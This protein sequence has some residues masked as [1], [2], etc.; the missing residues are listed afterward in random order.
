M[1]SKNP[2]ILKEL[3]YTTY[4]YVERVRF[5][6][7]NIIQPDP[8]TNV[9]YTI[10]GKAP[11][12]PIFPSGLTI[13]SG[14]T[15]TNGTEQNGYTLFTDGT[16]YAYWDL[17]PTQGITGIT[18][19]DG[20]SAQTTDNLTTIINIDKGSSQNI[21]KNFKV[22][23]V[24]QFGASSNNDEINFS[25]INLTITSAGT[26]TLVFSAKTGGGVSGITGGTYYPS[27]LTLDLET[28][29]STISINDVTGLY[30]SGGTYTSGTSTLDLFNSTGGTISITGITAGSG[31]SVF[32]GLTQMSEA[33]RT[34]L[35][36]T[37]GYMVYQTDG[38]D[39]VYVYK[40]GG[41]VQMI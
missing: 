19:T 12:N 8:N 36:P 11:I 13:N 9:I 10:G 34:G 23:G 3:Q 7:P 20:L 33:T 30:I 41:W 25:G 22:D 4:S 21:F 31:S 17:G 2:Y 14:F 39:G 29:G 6:L 18:A 5:A 37:I 35:T 16:G 38:S 24:T 32:T 15:Y 28:T 27:I 26:N 1:A 40:A